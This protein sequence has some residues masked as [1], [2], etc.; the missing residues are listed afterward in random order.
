MLEILNTRPAIFDEKRFVPRIVLP[1]IEAGRLGAPLHP[2]MERIV[3]ALGF[4]SY[5]YGTSLSPRPG[6]E[7]VSYV[8]TNMHEAWVRRYDDHAYIE[9]D[10]RLQHSYE[11]AGALI[12]DQRTERG[13]AA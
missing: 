1:L 12:W 5:M 8:F 11:K 6:H 13:K 3:A 2:V 4:D 9:V 7:A 10:P